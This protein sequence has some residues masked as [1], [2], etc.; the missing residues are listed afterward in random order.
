MGIFR[1]S[2]EIENRGFATIQ[3]VFSWPELEE[4][5]FSL[6]DHSLN[7]SRA[8][9]RHAM[10]IP[11]VAAIAMHPRLLDLA[12]IVLGTTPFPYRAT[13]F[14]KSP[15]SNWLVVWHQDTDLPVKHRAERS[16]W[17]SWSQKGNVLYA[18]AP[19]KVLSKILAL[20][21]HL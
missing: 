3:S 13:F 10:A 14:D 19:A 8:G 15:D 1:I 4:L 7:R 16:G 9:V 2:G 18:H 17:Q 21:I 6:Q 5:Q 12:R 11:A 20:R